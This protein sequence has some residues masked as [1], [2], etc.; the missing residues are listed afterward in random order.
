MVN[1]CSL[2]TR[3]HYQTMTRAAAA[4]YTGTSVP[5]TDA[6]HTRPVRM[7]S[8]PTAAGDTSVRACQ[9]TDSSS[10]FSSL[11]SHLHLRRSSRRGITNDP[12]TRRVRFVYQ[13]M[14][15]PGL[16][17]RMLES[18]KHSP[19]FR[20]S[21]LGLGVL[22]LSGLQGGCVMR[23]SRFSREG[24]I[25]MYLSMRTHKS[26]DLRMRMN[27]WRQFLSRASAAE[28]FLYS[29]FE[30]FVSLFFIILLQNS[31]SHT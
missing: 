13:A 2:R 20:G 30:R 17:R 10:G 3:S 23:G 5:P 1:A 26:S 7:A 6:F 12:D 18:S 28:N 19:V 14:G 8:G 4:P 24:D 29:L 31:M 9:A 25:G 11:W 27:E 22:L 16:E 15:G 21:S